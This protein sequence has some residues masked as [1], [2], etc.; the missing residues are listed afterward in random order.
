VI[1]GAD[2]R[3]RFSISKKD[4]DVLRLK[5]EKLAAGQLRLIPPPKEEPPPYHPVAVGEVIKYVK[6]ENLTSVVK[7][8]LERES[9]TQFEIGGVLAFIRHEKSQ[10]IEALAYQDGR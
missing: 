4:A 1:G 9:K 7:E 2:L 5:A 8:L 6:Q 3:P 10:E